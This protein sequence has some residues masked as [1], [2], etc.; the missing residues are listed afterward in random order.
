MEHACRRRQR[1]LFSYGG[2]KLD[3]PDSLILHL[4]LFLRHTS[5]NVE[6]VIVNISIWNV[7]KSVL[8]YLGIPFA[9]GVATRFSLI[10]K[11]GKKWYG[12]VFM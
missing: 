12:E 9:A 7:A 11:K 8:I 6:A 5:S 2:F 3:F 1:V 10:K 4:C